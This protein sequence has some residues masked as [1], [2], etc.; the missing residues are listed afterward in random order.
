[1]GRGFVGVAG[2]GE[3][4]VEF[5]E[6]F[7]Q[8][9]GF[10]AQTRGFGGFVDFHFQHQARAVAHG[11]GCVF[12]FGQSVHRFG[13]GEAG[14]RGQVF[15]QAFIGIAFD[16]QRCFHIRC[17]AH[18]AAQVAYRANQVL[19]CGHFVEGRLNDFAFIGYRPCGNH[20]AVGLL[21]VGQRRDGLPQFFGDVRHDWMQQAQNHFEGA[22]Q[23]AAGGALGGRAAGLDLHFG[24]LDVP[25]AEIVP[26]KF[27]QRL[28]G[29]VEAVGVEGF[30]YGGFGL[31]QAADNP[32]V[33]KGVGQRIGFVLAAV[34]VF[35]IHQ[36]EV[37]GV[38][39]FIAEVAVTF[40]AFEIEIH[41]AAEAGIAGHGKAQGIGAEHGNAFGEEFLRGFNH[42]RCFFWAAQAGGAFHQQLLQIDAINQIHRVN[43]V[44]F[45]FRHF[46]AFVVAH[47]AVDVHVFKRH[48]AGEVGGHHNHARHPE[49]DDFVAGYQHIAWQKGFQF[50][51]FRRPAQ[52]RKRHERR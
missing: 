50:V 2:F 42:L 51:G 24:Q 36:H 1:M 45:G 17:D 40:G 39:Q 9:L 25:V 23:R 41:T 20:D 27:I 22:N 16:K 35:H 37:G 26:H 7:L 31:L 29:E 5:V 18:F 6:G 46:F 33:N 13:F 19:Q 34:F 15:E 8:L 21:G 10:F 32:L 12:A 43:H 4:G 47:D 48:F 30:G 28:R 38:P 11:H 52:G 3:F 14:H 49:E 44:A